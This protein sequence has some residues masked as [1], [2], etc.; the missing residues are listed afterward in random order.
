MKLAKALKVKNTLVKEIS[1]LAQ[2]I[3]V[4]NSVV[5]GSEQPYNSKNLLALY[6]QKTQDLIDLKSKISTANATIQSS[7]YRI[8]E[9]KSQISHLTNVNTRSG[10][11]ASHSHSYRGDTEVEY[12]ATISTLDLEGIIIAKNTEID[13][14]QEAIDQYNYTTEI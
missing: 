3:N 1:D 6:E 2:K 5:I 4:Y 7:I 9:L 14:L 10:R 13:S 12:V 8:A 11:I